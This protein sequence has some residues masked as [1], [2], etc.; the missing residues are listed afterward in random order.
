MLP[1][2]WTVNSAGLGGGARGTVPARRRDFQVGARLDMGLDGGDGILGL[3]T[4]GS[5]RT[6]VGFSVVPGR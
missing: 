3:R 4:D 1:G 2:R 5:T 6:V